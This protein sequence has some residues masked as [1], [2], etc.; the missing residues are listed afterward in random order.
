MPQGLRSVEDIFY[1]FQPFYSEVREIGFAFVFV[2][3]TLALIHEFLL[4]VQGKSDYRAL[5]IRALLITGLFVIYTPFF[6]EVTHGM[7]LLSNFFMP[8]EEFNETIKKV[9]T[10]YR[11][12]KDLGMMAFLKMSFLE[13][14]M[15]GTYN[16]AYWVIRIF[17]W[18]RLVFLSAL[19]ISG[20][21]FLGVGMFQPKMAQT[22]VRWIFEVSAWN[23]VL[24]L[25]MRVLTQLDFF[26]LYQSANTPL[27]DLVAMNL[28]MIL[29]ITFFV[30]TFSAMMIRGASGFS[31]AGGAVLGFGGAMLIRQASK[32][33]R[34]INLMSKKPGGG[35]VRQSLGQAAANKS[36]KGVT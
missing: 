23:V 6:R 29:I 36:Y 30:P 27:L 14:A 1:V 18:V 15:Q 26:E 17:N 25:F 16:L 35:L 22:W 32:G 34:G 33:V 11:Q 21:I 9:F 12:K 20:P 2:F 4:G 13:W 8:S 3:L 7:Q 31:G 5:F 28:V 10:A 24:S 19:Y